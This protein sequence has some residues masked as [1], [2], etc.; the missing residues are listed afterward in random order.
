MAVGRE[1][2][3]AGVDGAMVSVAADAQGFKKIFF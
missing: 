3:P 2:Y 1:E